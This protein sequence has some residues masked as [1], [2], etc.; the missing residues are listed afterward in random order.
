MEITMRKTFIKPY[1]V[2]C[3]QTRT[4]LLQGTI[5]RPYNTSKAWRIILVCKWI[6]FLTTITLVQKREKTAQQK[7]A[8][9]K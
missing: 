2:I 7:L 6:S 1:Q 9:T 8:N 3:H 5:N 4:N